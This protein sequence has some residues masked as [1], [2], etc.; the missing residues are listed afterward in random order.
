MNGNGPLDTSDLYSFV[1]PKFM[2]ANVSAISN[3]ENKA[4]RCSEVLNN[5]IV[6]TGEVYMVEPLGICSYSTYAIIIHMCYVGIVF[7]SF[8]CLHMNL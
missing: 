3:R 1:G 5:G 4:I 7:A 2:I 8:V 6:I